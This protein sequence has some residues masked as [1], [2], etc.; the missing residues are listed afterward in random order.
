M[1]KE[2]NC[3]FAVILNEQCGPNRGEEDV[4]SLR[5]CLHDISNHLRNCHLS[6][7]NVT[8]VTL[9]LARAGL[10]D[11]GV[12]K[13]KDMTVCPKHRNNL[14]RYWQSPRTCQYP[15]HSGKLKKVE[16][17]NVINFKT[18]KEVLTLFGEKIQVGSPICTSCRKKHKEKLE[19]AIWLQ[20]FSEDESPISE[21]SDR[22]AKQEAKLA[23][24]HVI[25]STPYKE[26]ATPQKT[27]NETDVDWNP[28]VSIFEVSLSEDSLL[29]TYNTTMNLVAERANAHHNPL[30]FQL[31]VPWENTSQETKSQ[32]V[33]KAREDCLLVCNM[34]APESG[35][36]LYNA[37]T[38]QHEIEPSP[39][40]EALMTAY[41]NAKTSGLRTQIL[42]L[43]AF[44]YPIPVLMKLHE[45]YEKITRYQVKRARSHA[46]LHGPGTILEK[47][48]K[49]RVRLDMAKVD[50][51]LE[52]ANRPYL[53]GRGRFK[54]YPLVVLERSLLARPKRRG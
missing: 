18:A 33:D 8:E 26:V 31:D 47:E 17:G 16:D 42:S 50:H 24:K 53:I 37:L 46:K 6:R 28:E 54:V 48:M 45:P 35:A 27:F 20:S 19:K 49:H 30:T 13:V 9:I 22:Y 4:V 2:V 39:E 5:E 12:S 38:S 1:S 43:Y 25:S 15:E 29:S 34:I 51:F 10:F 32:C 14:G 23:I 21:G 36:E 3:S 52:F 11:L 40:M 7:E 41:R 44:K